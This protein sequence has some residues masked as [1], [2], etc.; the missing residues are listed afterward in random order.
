MC[1]NNHCNQFTDCI[2]YKIAKYW[3]QIAQFSFVSLQKQPDRF[4]TPEIRVA[5]IKLKRK[6]KQTK[7]LKQICCARRHL[8]QT[9]R[10]ISSFIDF[11]S[12]EN[13]INLILKLKEHL[14][15]CLLLLLKSKNAKAIDCIVC[16]GHDSAVPKYGYQF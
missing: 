7:Q 4:L 2:K 5:T 3:K 1:N 11:Q 9:A 8:T 12:I 10:S 15:V 13:W 6:I 16:C 14:F